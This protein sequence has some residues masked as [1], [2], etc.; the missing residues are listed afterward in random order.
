M[1]IALVEHIRLICFQL[2][3]NGLEV[4]PADIF[5][6]HM[7]AAIAGT[8]FRDIDRLDSGRC[9]IELLFAATFERD[10]PEGSRFNTMAAGG[11]QTVV[12]MDR[13]FHPFKRL[14]DI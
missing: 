2:I 4:E 5:A 13:S 11:H 9:N 3:P 8:I 6:A 7:L 1:D 10:K 12:L 14:G